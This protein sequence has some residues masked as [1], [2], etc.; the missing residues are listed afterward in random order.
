[1]NVARNLQP[2]TR[3][4]II[5]SVVVVGLLVAVQLTRTDLVAP[6][7]DLGPNTTIL[8]VAMLIALVI[9]CLI[10]DRMPSNPVGW[11]LVLLGLF[12]LFSE[13]VGEYAI[14]ALFRDPGSLPLGPEAAWLYSWVWVG[15]VGLIPPLL[16]YFP[17]GALPS[18][19]WK[20]VLWADA[21]FATLFFVD[22]LFLWSE[23][24]PVFL[25]VGEVT[26][27]EPSPLQTAVSFLGIGLLVFVL[28]GCAWGMV[29]RYRRAD[30]VERHQ[31]KWLAFASVYYA[32][33]ILTTYMIF[34]AKVPV[35]NLLTNF[36]IASLPAA[37]GVAVFKYRLY[38]IDVVI[39]KALVYGSLAAFIT[40]IYV[41]IVV[42]V[43]TLIGAGDDP[44]LGL[45][46]V[47]TA[48]IAVAF[49]PFKSR[50][51]RLANR[52]VYGKRSTPYE[53]LAEFS[54]KMSGSYAQDE[55]LSQMASTLAEG[56]GAA[57]A[58]VWVKI[59]DQIRLAASYHRGS[60]HTEEEDAHE[61]VTLEGGDLKIPD[62]DH[63]V[64]VSHKGELLG[65]LAITKRA[66]EAVTPVE[67]KLMN[68][69]AA[70]A[71]VVLR[72]ARLNV[73]LLL[74]LEELRASRQRLVAAANQARRRL[75]RDLHDGAQQQLVALKVKLSLAQR[76]T[77]QEKVKVFLTQLQAEADDALQTL[78]DLARGIYPPLLADKGLPM[79]L[80][81]QAN[82]T[83]LD[84]EVRAEGVG[85][86][87]QE[88][89]AAVYFCCLEA[90]QNVAK[91]AGPCEVVI[92][93]ADSGGNLSFEVKDDGCGFDSA[94]SKRGHGLQNMS[95][96]VDALGG[97]ISVSS[98]PGAGTTVTGRIP[99]HSLEPATA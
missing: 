24:G 70:Q 52:L 1:V 26:L 65:A 30:G 68:D 12:G 87:P 41:G 88:V 98:S 38:D 42:G 81:A 92:T 72:N 37:I 51:Q 39:N 2:R 53:V 40:A 50:V 33:A 23:R 69:L 95:D 77:T 73:E 5:L 3:A 99:V 9:G 22:A 27:G 54:T 21:G 6:G 17:N 93:L 82:K 80:T 13:L 16:L 66:G 96:R 97:E 59:G 31:L 32:L 63:V 75:E 34:S 79:A 91:Y 36:S 20:V 58:H 45:S 57:S 7:V 47:A 71:G 56:T 64:R 35:L 60:A 15:I 4:A 84:V 29:H 46:I 90:L 18:R 48:L 76:L 44:N 14:Y 10:V 78:R 85:R 19:R 67:E 86:Y 11:I 62:S 25:D 61:P 28:A 74:R 83:S 43:G 89:E 55:L 8:A 49:Q 94:D